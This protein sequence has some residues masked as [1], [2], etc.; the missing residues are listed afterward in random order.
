MA[1]KNE[2]TSSDDENS[3]M[4]TLIVEVNGTEI[5]NRDYTDKN[6]SEVKETINI[7]NSLIKDAADGKYNIH[8]KATNKQKNI[9]ENNLVLEVDDNKPKITGF[10]VN[11]KEMSSEGDTGKYTYI[12][13]QKIEAEIKE[14]SGNHSGI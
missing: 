8:I 6:L 3:E 10:V 13:S 11:G 2:M 14:V 9:A 1:K 5:L 7:S 12:T 4:A